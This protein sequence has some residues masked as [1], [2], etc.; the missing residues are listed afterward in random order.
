MSMVESAA[1]L[2]FGSFVSC[3]SVEKDAKR[4]G[5]EKLK[6]RKDKFYNWTDFV[7]LVLPSFRHY[8]LS[9]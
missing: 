8:P 1:C 7:S 9:F 3:A 5:V 4:S 2:P 6:E